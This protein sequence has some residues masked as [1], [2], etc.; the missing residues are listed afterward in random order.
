MRRLNPVLYIFVALFI[1][2]CKTNHVALLNERSRTYNENLQW[3]NV[4]AASM[5][6]AKSN[7]L[8]L[9]NELSREFESNK[10]VD[11]GILD[12]AL[13][14]NKQKASVLV[15]YS[16]YGNDQT[17]KKARQV[18]Y[19]EFQEKSWFLTRTQRLK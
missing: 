15:E 1:Y 16:Y 11:F 9:M 13:D 8:D 17:L 19:W 3:Q 2:Q 18:Q 7:R 14:Q 5:F 12:I 6:F 10:V 4:A